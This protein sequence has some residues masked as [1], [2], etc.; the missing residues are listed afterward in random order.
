MTNLKKKI[1]YLEKRLHKMKTLRHSLKCFTYVRVSHSSIYIF[2]TLKRYYHN[3]ITKKEKE[4]DALKETLCMCV[5]FFL[6]Y[7]HK[8]FF[9]TYINVKI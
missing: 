5:C 4:R 1:I 6:L 8:F 9:F 2:I 3:S 7:T